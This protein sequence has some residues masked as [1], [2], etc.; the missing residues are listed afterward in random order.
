VVLYLP[1]VPEG[2]RYQFF[3]F[4]RDRPLLVLAVV[5][6]LAVLALA[7]WRGLLSLV[8]LAVS[9]VVVVQF[10]LPGLLGSRP[11]L[12]VAVVGASVIMITSLY[13]THGFNDRTSVALIGTLLSLLLTGAIG[14]AVVG[15]SRFTG[16]ADE[17]SVYLGV[18]VEGIDFSGLLLA[19][20]V[21]GALG[22]LDDVTV[23]QAA[24]VWELARADPQMSLRGLFTA[25]MRIGRSH[26][27][28]TVNTLVLAYIGASL[29]LM[30]IFTLTDVGLV[31]AL[32]TEVV[33]QEVARG[34]VGSLGIVA[35]VP[36]TT[37]VAA[38]V[39]RPPTGGTGR[40]RRQ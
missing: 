12:L 28:A 16:L 19:G 7:R 10:V 17:T 30:L 3:D 26:V 18:L 15:V 35:A 24:A 36:I 20:L 22:V 11:P 33:A 39:V 5:F 9:V 1:D 31:D 29:P 32:T 25:A 38:L 2:E 4:D 40:R 14:A 37:A 21:I 34:L 6:A 8:S 23:T 27:Q 13:L